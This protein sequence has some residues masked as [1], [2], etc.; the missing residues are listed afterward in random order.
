MSSRQNSTVADSDIFGTFD[1]DSSYK[2]PS[3]RYS[4][5]SRLLTPF[6]NPLI[7]M[8]LVQTED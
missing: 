3:S 2:H 8:G 4:H 6:M 1:A 7:G 5:R